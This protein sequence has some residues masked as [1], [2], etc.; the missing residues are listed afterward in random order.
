MHNFISEFKDLDIIESNEISTKVLFNT[1]NYYFELVFPQNIYEWF[2][3]MYD[4]NTEE[5][6]W[7]N[8]SEWYTSGDVT[9]GNIDNFY[10]E[11]KD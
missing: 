1:Q 5:E 8:W 9:K 7:N 10:K 3:T 4:N 6:V 2:V 11:D